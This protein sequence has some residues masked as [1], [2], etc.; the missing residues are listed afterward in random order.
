MFLLLSTIL[1]FTQ[2]LDHKRVT[3]IK[4]PILYK[5]LSNDIKLV[6]DV[7]QNI[8]VKIKDDGMVF[9]KH[10]RQNSEPITIDLKQIKHDN[11]EIH[12]AD[13]QLKEK[14]SNYLLPTTT[15]LDVMPDSICL[16]YSKQSTKEL[17][18]ALDAN[19]GLASQYL[20][21]DT[22][23]ITPQST[24]VYGQKSVIDTM[25]SVLTEKISITELQ[26][27]TVLKVKLRPPPD[28]VKYEN[29][30][31]D[32]TLY[33]ERFTERKVTLPIT[34]INN[35][36]GAKIKLFPS[37]TTVTYNVGLSNYNKVK[38]NDLKPIFD[39]QKAKKMGNGQ[40][41]LEIINN[42]SYIKNINLFPAQ[43]EF[44]IEE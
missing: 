36:G 4:I 11:G 1:W 43:V 30:E 14:L 18:I 27:T 8:F 6:G 3:T 40:Y 23:K 16:D 29:K 31:V 10:Y 28:G 25:K 19:I 12:I 24:K 26:D 22:I 33:V 38:Y 42:S 37:T 41:K 39:L 5:G 21:A 15:L 35:E 7:Q 2:A 9:L 32:I 13:E 20:F 17:P 34:I 44:L